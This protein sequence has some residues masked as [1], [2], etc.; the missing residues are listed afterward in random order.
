MLLFI[1]SIPLQR[2]GQKFVKHFVGFLDDLQT[3]IFFNASPGFEEGPPNECRVSTKIINKWPCQN[4]NKVIIIAPDDGIY[5]NLTCTSGSIFFSL[6]WLSEFKTDTMC[7]WFDS[8]YLTETDWKFATIHLLEF[9]NPSMT[10]ETSQSILNFVFL[11]S[12]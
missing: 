6:S 10:R 4:H 12:S 5:T 11:N 7:F 9:S 3:R 2:L 8:T 1:V